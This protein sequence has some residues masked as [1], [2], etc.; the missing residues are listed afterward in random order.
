MSGSTNTPSCMYFSNAWLPVCRAGDD[1]Y[2]WVNLG[3]GIY[4]I[5]LIAGQRDEEAG[6]FF[7]RVVEVMNHGRGKKKQEKIDA[8]WKAEIEW[9]AQVAEEL[10]KIKE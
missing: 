8:K 5:W 7:G 2:V 10:V 1:K 6:F 9:S 3:V 4:K